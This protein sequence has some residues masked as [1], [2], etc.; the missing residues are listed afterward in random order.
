MK[1]ACDVYKS[2]KKEDLY[3]YVR[4]DDGLSKVPADLLSTF[5]TPEKALSFTLTPD[6]TLAKEDPGEVMANLEDKGYHLQMPPVD[7]RFRG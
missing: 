4:S 1:I 6:R 3:I 7:D 2:S 5:G